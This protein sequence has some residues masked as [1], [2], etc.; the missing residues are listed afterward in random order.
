MVFYKGRIFDGIKAYDSDHYTWLKNETWNA[1][2]YQIFFKASWG[3]VDVR[4]YT[5]RG[6]FPTA[7]TLRRSDFSSEA[8]F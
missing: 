7:I 8:T 5:I 4:D 6:Y 1:G 3:S 2:N